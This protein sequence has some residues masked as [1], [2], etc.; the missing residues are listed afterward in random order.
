MT[1][2]AIHANGTFWG[3]FTAED[4]AAAV[5]MAADEFGTIDVGQAHAVTEG[6][7]A[8]DL[9]QHILALEA[10]CR[11]NDT[12]MADLVRE[13]FNCSEVEIDD[14]GDVWIAGPQTG[15]WLDADNLGEVVAFVEGA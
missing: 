3:T 1:D 6:M 2:Y 9:R 11:E 10:A 7:T 5:Q 14:K 13:K 8:T 4:E 15:H 12:D